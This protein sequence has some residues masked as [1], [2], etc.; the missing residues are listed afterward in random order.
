MLCRDQQQVEIWRV[1]VEQLIRWTHGLV[2]SIMYHGPPTRLVPR[3]DPSIL[4]KLISSRLL[5]IFVDLGLC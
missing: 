3:A 1:L 5:Q 4:I 2:F